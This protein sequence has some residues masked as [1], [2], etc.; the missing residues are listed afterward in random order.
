[1]PVKMRLVRVFKLVKLRAMISSLASRTCSSVPVVEACSERIRLEADA[2]TTRVL[3][4][5]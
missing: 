1:V 3:E 5:G 4:A 2:E